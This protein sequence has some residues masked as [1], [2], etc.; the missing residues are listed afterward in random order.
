MA[1]RRIATDCVR[2]MKAPMVIMF[3]CTFMRIA[4][5]TVSAYLIGGM[6]DSLLALDKA[7]ILA[8]LPY[9]I[10]SIVFTVVVAPLSSFLENY[11]L[12]RKGYQYDAFLV[13]RYMG[14]NL[15]D[16]EKNGSGKLIEAMDIDADW[17]YSTCQLYSLPTVMI[18]YIAFLFFLL[19]KE[20]S[21][22]TTL[23]VV[24]PMV[25]IVRAILVGPGQGRSQKYGHEYNAAR[26][27]IEEKVVPSSDWLRSWKMTGFYK[28]L[29]EE[30]LQKWLKKNINWRIRFESF[31][32]SSK[33]ILDVLVQI[34]VLFGG[35][36]LISKGKLTTGELLAGWLMLESV[37]DCYSEITQWIRALRSRKELREG[38]EIFYGEM[39]DERVSSI[40]TSD[41]LTAEN[42]HFSYEDGTVLDGI[43]INVRKGENYRLIGENG[44]G[45]STFIRILTGL[46]EPQEGSI[47]DSHGNELTLRDLRKLVTL[48]EQDSDVF[49]GTVREN[50]FS[51]DDEKAE[52]LLSRL[53]FEKSLDYEMGRG[54]RGLSPGEKKKL[55]LARA[56]LRDSDYL[57][58]DEPLNHLDA[59]GA[60]VLEKELRGKDAGKVIITHKDMNMDFDDVLTLQKP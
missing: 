57:I 38:M 17:C 14:K 48:A 27:E 12:V 59:A 11:L 24:V 16:I 51:L 36:I 55:I 37:E 22:F 33:M 25:F 20:S 34:I 28:D 46:Y 8:R 4:F 9:L 10:A 47:R 52:K 30:T 42:I 40:S 7:A 26:R 41:S 15:R 2:F 1:D 32:E 54:G 53:G 49:S 39:E 44:A 43:N 31:I 60:A 6:T 35:V 23:I 18:V 5:P 45:K 19:G 56:L 50:L 29:I 21:I 13:E 58:L 3:F